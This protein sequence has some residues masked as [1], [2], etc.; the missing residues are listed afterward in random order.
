LDRARYNAPSTVRIT[1]IDTDQAGQPSETVHV[2]STTEPAGE[3]VVLTAA[4]SGGSFTG[5]IATAIGPPVNDGELQVAN[6]DT[7]QVVYFDASANANRIATA[8]AD[9][10]APVLGTPSV[11]PSFGKEVVSWL[12]SEPA[13]SK[14]YYGTNAVLSSLTLVATNAELT[15]N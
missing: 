12:S 3:N 2:T 4:G 13:T 10:A 14:V 15:I 6:N 1:L 7:M 8:V 5:A 11:A 9:L